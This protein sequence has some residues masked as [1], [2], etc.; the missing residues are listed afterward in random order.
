MILYSYV[1]IYKSYNIIFYI[2]N[3]YVCCCCCCCVVCC[4]LF[5]VV[6]VVVVLNK[7]TNMNSFPGH[8]P[9]RGCLTAAWSPRVTS[10]SS[11][12]WQVGCYQ[13][14]LIN[15]LNQSLAIYPLV[16]SK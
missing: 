13:R 5:V 3:K 9:C 4:L 10:R 8:V 6:A 1:Y 2:H 14:F 12:S 16:M 7:K 15:N 11:G